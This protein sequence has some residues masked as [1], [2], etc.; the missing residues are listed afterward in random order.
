MGIML[1]NAKSENDVLGKDIMDII[2]PAYRNVVAERIKR[3]NEGSILPI[4]DD[5]KL[6]RFD[7][8]VVLVEV[9]SRRI[10]YQGQVAIQS[11]F[12]DIGERK[13]IEDMLRDAANF[14]EGVVETIW[15][16]L[17]VVDSKLRV[18][19]VNKAFCSFFCVDQSAV[20]HQVLTEIEGGEWD[21]P[22]LLAML[23]RAIDSDKKFYKFEMERSFLKVGL[24]IVRISIGKIKKT[25]ML[26]PLILVSV[27]DVTEERKMEARIMQYA[28]QMKQEKAQEKAL[29]SSLGVGTV[30]IDAD[31]NILYV[32]KAFEEITKIEL[33]DMLGKK[34][35][36][37]VPFFDQQNVRIAVEELPTEKALA[38]GKKV[39]VGNVGFAPY[40]LQRKSEKIA[41]AVTASPVIF[42][43][44]IRGVIAIFREVTKEREVDRAKTEFISLASHQLR[45]PLAGISLSSELLLKGVAGPVTEEQKEY[46]EEIFASTKRMSTLVGTLLNISRVEMGTIVLR[47]DSLNPIQEVE[48]VAN[49]LKGLV[50]SKGLTLIKKFDEGVVK[51][52]FDKNAF[53]IMVENIISNAIRYT[54]QN[55]TVVV[56][57]KQDKDNL[58]FSVSDT[59]CGVPEDEYEKI[60]TRLF[61][62]EKAKEV[63][64]EGVGLGLYMTKLLADK[65][66]SKIWLESK[67]GEGTT[68]TIAFPIFPLS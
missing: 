17:I 29:L 65:T 3:M 15:E 34:F 43:N 47:S 14:S 46:L 44:K 12:H 2:E 26:K 27:E 1:V 58:L 28:E 56:S 30:S 23:K 53:R 20:Q 4:L 9:V 52:F 38:T 13:Q 67:E 35:S 57:L 62:S 61:R 31:G 64:V 8:S 5:L 59:G 11:I 33:Q 41:V 18:R 63:S 66:N 48:A 54:P 22:E 19:F 40:Y 68:F 25:S 49:D 6:R 10:E 51:I 36:D 50:D 45:T 55:G 42:E 21:I 24:K 16:P 32:N 39:I 7:E 37:I 60:F